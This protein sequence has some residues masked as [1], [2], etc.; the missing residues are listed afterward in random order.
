MSSELHNIELNFILITW[1]SVFFFF[2]LFCP[3]ALPRTSCNLPVVT[4]QQQFA[5]LIDLNDFEHLHIK[6]KSLTNNYLNLLV[7]QTTFLCFFF[8]FLVIVFF[9]IMLI[10][11]NTHLPDKT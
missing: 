8:F 9:I 1:Y 4:M 2:F 5:C 11:Y 10:K 7:T 6:Q 3:E